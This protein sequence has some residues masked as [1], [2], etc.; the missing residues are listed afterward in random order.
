MG[1]VPALR[2]VL[3]MS[4]RT[5][6]HLD[7]QQAELLR[8]LR[9]A[10]G[11]IVSFD[12][13]RAI[14][15]ENPAVVCYELEVAGVSIDRVPSHAA[16]TALPV[17][18]RLDEW[19]FRLDDAPDGPLQR[20]PTAVEEALGAFDAALDVVARESRRLAARVGRLATSPRPLLDRGRGLGLVALL[21][22]VA[23]AGIA[24]A[25]TAGSGSPV[26]GPAA[27]AHAI[28]RALTAASHSRHASR[29][30]GHR[31]FS[32]IRPSQ[33]TP[34]AASAAA[35]QAAA[36]ESAPPPSSTGSAPAAAT[37]TSTTGGSS[38]GLG[39]GTTTAST[40]PSARSPAP[41]HPPS[42]ASAATGGTHGPVA[43]SAPVAAARSASASAGGNVM[44]IQAEGHQLL[45]E[46]R[47]APAI[48]RLRAAISA[49]GQSIAA[50]ETASSDACLAYAYA[51]Y[52]LGRALRLDGDPAAAI[53]VLG[54][55]LR[56]DNQR[57]VV[58][59]E[60]ALAQREARTPSGG[61]RSTD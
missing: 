24:L 20:A 16:A 3:S 30:S 5:V 21:A 8:R 45:G 37:A 50:C 58:Q 11:E 6:D 39:T 15:I 18:V 23:V 47:Y 51:L 42:G 31:A 28:A 46:G 54:E 4:S 41:L 48:E 29:S 14:G 26:S 59:E 10:R 60:L 38:S 33:P 43:T 19:D 13:L 1:A 52:D 49:S 35:T 53:P 40:R 27:N 2:W 9:A 61:S 55:R 32:V 44:Q 36:P 17:G 56:I 7:K 22:I 34:A 12:E 25:L 57:P